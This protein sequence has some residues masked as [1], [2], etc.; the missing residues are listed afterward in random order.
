[1]MMNGMCIGGARLACRATGTRAAI[2]SVR[3]VCTVY[4]R[5]PRLAVRPRLTGYALLAASPGMACGTGCT[6]LTAQARVPHAC[7]TVGSG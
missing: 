2:G 4:A 3:A 6:R 1:M 5:S 7:L